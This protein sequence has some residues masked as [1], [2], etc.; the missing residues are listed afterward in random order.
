MNGLVQNQ[1]CLESFLRDQVLLG[2]DQKGVAVERIRCD[3]G[4]ENLESFRVVGYSGQDDLGGHAFVKDQAVGRK[5][6]LANEITEFFRK[7]GEVLLKAILDGVEGAIRFL[8]VLLFENPFQCGGSDLKVLLSDQ[9]RAQ[10]ELEVVGQLFPATEILQNPDCFERFV[11]VVVDEG[12]LKKDAG[13]FGIFLEDF[14]VND[15][16]FLGA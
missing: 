12:H 16:G 9:K 14:F 6:F 5:V 3:E 11:L 1:E 13:V 2:T 10:K 15:E 7:W 8:E 4:I